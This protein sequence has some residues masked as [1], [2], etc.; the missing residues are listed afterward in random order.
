MRN[1]LDRIITGNIITLSDE[2][3]VV[4]AVG[5][6]NDL[7]VALGA[8]EN[9]K[10]NA[11][12]STEYLDLAGKTILPGFIDTHVH[13]C[14]TGSSALSVNL[15]DAVSIN[16][17]LERIENRVAKTQAGEM[18]SATRFNYT[19]ITENRM[20]TMTELDGVSA[21]HSIVITCFDGHSFMIN[22][23]VFNGLGLSAEEE[24]VER[25][26]GGNPTGLIEDPAIFKVHNFLTPKKE[27]DLLPLLQ[28]AANSALQAGITT[29]HAKETSGTMEVLLANE[30]S[31]PI[32]I[33]P[34]YLFSSESLEL[35][36]KLVDSGQ[37]KDLAIVGFIAD[38][39][40]DSKTAA[41][42]EP[43]PGDET[44]F[45]VLFYTD[46]ELGAR[47]GKAHRA[48]Y[49]VSVHACGARCIEQVLNVYEQVLKNNPREDHRH[50][51]EH[52]ETPSA[53]QLQRIAK[54]GIAASMHPQHTNIC[55]GYAENI[56]R[57]VGE[58]MY[59]RLIPLRSALDAGVLVAGGSDSPVAPMAPLVAIHD[60]V[61]HPNPKHRISLYEALRMF[62]IDAARIGFEEK[63]KG[64]IEK[65]K[66]ADLVVLT[67]N[68]YVVD[69]GK[70]RD[71]QIEKTFVGGEI[72]YP[73][74]Q[75][76][77]I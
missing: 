25:D 31:L 29:I 23:M 41:Y 53:S 48:G 15:H 74:K 45:G 40:P 67:E 71:I 75:E 14:F 50:R 61:N 54:A 10:K 73:A 18:V 19:T 64:S 76:R 11:G 5:I 77:I 8:K 26:D 1:Q 16:D 49:Q 52:L 55:D 68:P 39:A 35:L 30:N 20:P 62:T 38:G 66:L 37:H 33:K 44:N 57:T 3:P 59:E 13:P 72:A 21:E 34:F 58:N 17:V 63:M 27:S 69:P 46:E 24:G 6:K 22:S 51:I 70:I 42:F 43:Y 2:T 56:R 65:G 36:D 4:E 32:R 12:D 7:I 9:V 60:C 47:I 28:A